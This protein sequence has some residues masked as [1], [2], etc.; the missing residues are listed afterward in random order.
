VLHPERVA[1][2]APT[3]YS[4]RTHEER[5]ALVREQPAAP[6]MHLGGHKN[7][8]STELTSDGTHLSR[9]WQL[10]TSMLYHGKGAPGTVMFPPE[11]LPSEDL[12]FVNDWIVAYLQSIHNQVPTLQAVRRYDPDARLP[13]VKAPTLVIQSTGP[14]EPRFLQ[15]ADMVQKLIPGSRVATIEGGDIHMIHFRAEELGAILLEF[16]RTA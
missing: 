2:L 3:G 9:I 4:Y 12:E 8:V 11:N 10:A 14:F 16:F 15:R 7:P 5:S 1:A 13:L 6:S